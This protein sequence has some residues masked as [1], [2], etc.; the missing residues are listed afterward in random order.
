M[1]IIVGLGN[2]GK[3]Y[4]LTRHNVGFLA[5][6]TFLK[7]RE[8]ITCQSK[9][10][11]EICEYHQDG[12]KIFFVKPQSFMNLSGEVVSEIVNFYK[13]DIEKDLLVIHDDKDLEFGKVK[14]TE[15]SGSAGQNG[16]QNIIDQL[17]TK[18]FH[19]IRIGVEA[20]DQD[21]PLST[22]DFVLQKFTDEELE[23]LESKLFL[24]TNKLIEQFLAK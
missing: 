6:D 23:Q 4:Q 14:F 1:R 17:G 2:P 12:T 13:V 7:D 19:R 24:E 16:V 15:G 5:V 18:T 10:N 9:F 20:R 22:S 3:Q 21:S 11:A 8:T